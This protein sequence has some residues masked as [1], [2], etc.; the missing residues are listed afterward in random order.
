MTVLDLTRVAERGPTLDLNVQLHGPQLTLGQQHRGP[1]LELEPLAVSASDSSSNAF[2]VSA[3]VV[4]GVLALA[5]VLPLSRMNVQLYDDEPAWYE[6]LI[7]Q[8]MALFG[9]DEPVVE[10][11][12]QE[13]EVVE[14]TAVSD[15]VVTQLQSLKGMYC[16]NFMPGGDQAAA[17]STFDTLVWSKLSADWQSKALE[18]VDVCMPFEWATPDVMSSGGCAKSMCGTEDVH[19]YINTQGKAALD[20]NIGGRC[21]YITEDGFTQ[22]SVLCSH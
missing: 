6:G 20:M 5:V 14:N 22:L 1:V 2:A 12:A 10:V 3:F 9:Q 13:P 18:R 11:E 8:V 16:F 21:S 19:F 4:A 7:S 17:V 15:D